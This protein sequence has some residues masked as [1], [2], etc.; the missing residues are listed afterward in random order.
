MKAAWSAIGF[1]VAGLAWF[2]LELSPQ[3]YG[4]EDTDSPRVMLAF[5]TEH[6]Q[7]FA[8]AGLCLFVM[9]F[10][11][12]WTVQATRDPA[13]MDEPHTA[14]A[15]VRSFGL[16][17]A[18]SFLVA[19]VLRF[20]NEPLLYISG[21]D[22]DWG[23]AGYVA[24]QLVTV[25]GFLQAAT[26]ALCIWAVGTAVLAYRSGLIGPVLGALAVIPAFR[27]LTLI[28]GPL[29]ILPEVLWLPSIAAILGTIAYA[30]LLAAIV[31]RRGTRRSSAGLMP[32]A[33]VP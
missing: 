6:A 16:I 19:G 14:A 8:F 24:L 17:A 27:L 18:G 30:G 13:E 33:S 25:H 4:F 5:L 11:L 10:T 9:A 29:G 1:T 7:L 12:T 2:G 26:I 28:G 3:V 32:A 23:E 31:L 20:S 21:L 15:T 22:R